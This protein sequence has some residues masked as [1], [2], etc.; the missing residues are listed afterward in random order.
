MISTKLLPRI[1]AD[2]AGAPGGG[3]QPIEGEPR[4]RRI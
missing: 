3:K 4:S 1:D 2:Q